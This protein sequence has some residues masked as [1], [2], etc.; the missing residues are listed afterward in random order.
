MRG[1][2]RLKRKFW[3]K[4]ILMNIIYVLIIVFVFTGIRFYTSVSWQKE[5]MGQLLTQITDSNSAQITGMINEMDRLTYNIAVT[6]GVRDTLKKACEYIG[7]NN[8]FDRN[9]VDKRSVIR[10]MQFLAGTSMK[11][12]SV[13][14]ISLKGDYV[15]LDTY[16]AQTLTRKQVLEVSQMDLFYKQNLNKQLQNVKKDRF[17]RTDE[18][19]FAYLRKVSDEYRDYGYVS[20]Q[21]AVSV[22]SEFMETSTENFDMTAVVLL[23]GELFYTTGNKINFD[24]ESLSALDC[25]ADSED[26]AQTYSEAVIDGEQYMICVSEKDKYGIQVFTLLPHEVYTKQIYRE[27]LLLFLQSAVLAVSMIILVALVS[28]QVYKPVVNL[29][30]KMEN[31]EITGLLNEIKGLE[32]TDAT[33]EIEAFNIVFANMIERMRIQNEEI[34]QIKTRALRASYQALRAQVN[35]H[36]LH[37]TLYLIGLMGEEHGAPE[38]LDM[39]SNLT[40]MMSYC[41][42][43]KKSVVTFGEEISYMMCYLE[44]MKSRYADKLQYVIHVEESIKQVSVPK[45]ILQPLVENCFTHGFKNSAEPKF[46]IRITLKMLQEGWQLLIEDNGVGISEEDK[47]RVES[48]IDYIRKTIW[49][50]DGAFVNEITG[51]GLVNTWTRLYISYSE[52]VKLKIRTSDMGGGLIELRCPLEKGGIEG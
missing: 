29:R 13:D 10:T 17:G 49:N 41:I 38:I 42:D 3:S 37:N 25:V 33:D 6:G 7:T 4:I 15:L 30:K 23:N 26:K 1:Y 14:L 9:I 12:T 43:N 24:T 52:N 51:I 34:I 32:K 27:I 2:M 20:V 22:V 39:C 5:N 8:Y 36:F 31:Y 11:N 28:N 50:S 47:E 48:N 16:A 21:K 19:M 45:F 44:L 46:K 18:N 40:R 35:P